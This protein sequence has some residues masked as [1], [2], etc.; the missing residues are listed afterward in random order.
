MDDLP[1]RTVGVDV[2]KNWLD[3]AL[4]PAARSERFANSAAGIAELVP[5]L[6]QQPVA[7]VVVE[8]TGGYEFAMVQALH[9]AT[10]P[11][12]VVNPRQIRDFAR[13]CGRLAK[14][15]AIDAAVIARFGEVMNPRSLPP[16]APSRQALGAL[17][18]RRRQLIDMLVA[19]KNRLRLADPTIESWIEETMS[20]LKSQLA[21]IDTA[22]ALAISRADDL[23]HRCDILTSVPGVGRLTAAVILA[24]MP[25]LGVIPAKKAA[26]LAGVAPINH[27]SGNHRGE[28]HIGG[29]RT[30]V[31]CALYMATLS[32]VRSEPSLKA[33][34]QRLRETKKPKV[35]LVACMR[36]LVG[37]LSALLQK[38]TF[39][40]PQQHGC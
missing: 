2:S 31:R 6:K 3:V 36:K 22:M 1:A 40:H 14:T 7:G 4:G 34:Y 19:E 13:A 38:D 16:V 28:R 18:A 30:S 32:A 11:V 23:G 9:A 33:F 26:A 35:A 20:A 27:D 15:D 29:G 10:I 37:I 21:A 39:W 25:E 12:A 17:V 8:A 5:A 24:E